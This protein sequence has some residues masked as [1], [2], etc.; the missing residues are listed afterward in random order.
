MNLLVKQWRKL[1]FSSAIF[2]LFSC[3]NQGDLDL[4]LNPDA[5]PV[6]IQY[7]EFALNTKNIRVD[8]LLTS[9][10]HARVV[11]LGKKTSD[12]F[13]STTSS[14]IGGF[15]TT[16]SIK[17][18]AVGQEYQFDTCILNLD[19]NLVHN[20]GNWNPQTYTVHRLNEA[21]LGSVYYLSSFDIPLSD[22]YAGLA[23][24]SSNDDELG[25]YKT[26]LNYRNTV[27]KTGL[28]IVSYQAKVGM[29]SDFGSELIGVAQG[30][31]LGANTRLQDFYKGFA[32]VPNADN[33]LLVEANLSKTV[34]NATVFPSSM[35]VIYHIVSGTEI[36]KTDTLTLSLNRLSYTKIDHDHSGSSFAALSNLQTTT[37]NPDTA[38]LNAAAG[39]YPMLELDMAIDYFDSLESSNGRLALINR[40]DLVT[41]IAENKSTSPWVDNLAYYYTYHNGVAR[42]A[43]VLTGNVLRAG[44]LRPGSEFF[45]AGLLSR[46]ASVY[47]ADFTVFFGQ[48]ENETIFNVAQIPNNT[49]IVMPYTSTSVASEIRVPKGGFK[50]KVWYTY[51][52]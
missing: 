13:G 12:V 35:E 1:L 38:Y 23:V 14:Y 42:G 49:L 44:I 28:Q 52:Q 51:I 25:K 3:S 29:P 24:W 32:I 6:S 41:E 47:N 22:A 20:T 11:A 18:K 39:I 17:A 46:D 4:Q 9:T 16:D 7:K 50:L 15:S 10:T 8:S 45:L 5:I 43:D 19:V 34:N 21:M 37:L 2:A 40:A 30:D 33:D 26:Y 27:D 31:R 48:L 36:V